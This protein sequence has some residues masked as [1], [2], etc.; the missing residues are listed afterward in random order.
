MLVSP[1]HGRYG[2]SLRLHALRSQNVQ[3]GDLFL[4]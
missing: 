2:Q 3:I 4:L 1:L